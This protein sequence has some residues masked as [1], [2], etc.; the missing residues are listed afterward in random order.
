MSGV[1]TT[2]QRQLGVKT[3]VDMLENV[4]WFRWE[5]NEPLDPSRIYAA[6]VE[7]GM[8]LSAF[9][10]LGHF[11]FEQGQART[12]GASFPYSG[13]TRASGNWTIELTGYEKKDGKPRVSSVLPYFEPKVYNPGK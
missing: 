8:G 3:Q 2:L 11:D 1:D 7:G 12:K 13:E 4:I 10:V 5:K 9:R 6:V